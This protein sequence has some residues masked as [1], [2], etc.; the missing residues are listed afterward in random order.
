VLQLFCEPCKRFLSDRFVEGI[1]P[2]CAYE[3][4]RGDQCDQCGRLMNSTEL[5]NPRC[6]VCGSHDVITKNSDQVI[7]TNNN[8]LGMSNLS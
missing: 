3:D 5:K 1:C 6:K 7:K 8:L 2:S 4:A